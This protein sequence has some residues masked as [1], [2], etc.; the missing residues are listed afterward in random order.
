MA[1]IKTSSLNIYQRDNLVLSDVNIE[2]ESGEFIYLIGKTG[3]GKSSL[4]RTFYAD[5]PVKEGSAEIAG[6]NL[7]NISKKNIPL[8]RRKLGIVFQDFQ[9]L[10][11]RNVHK[12][13]EFVLRCT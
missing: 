12:N 8:L 7:K 6:Y 2:I 11:D 9:L 4:L 10:S 1:I 5:I 3:T 13:L